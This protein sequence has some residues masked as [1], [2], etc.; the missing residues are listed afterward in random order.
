MVQMLPDAVSG[1]NLVVSE[2][3]GNST[4]LEFDPS[5]S[6]IDGRKGIRVATPDYGRVTLTADIPNHLFT[7]IGQWNTIE[8]RVIKNYPAYEVSNLAPFVIQFT[9]DGLPYPV[10]M[11]Y[12]QNA[13][14]IDTRAAIFH[15]HLKSDNSLGVVHPSSVLI[16][17]L[18]TWNG[19]NE[20][21]VHLSF[22]RETPSYISYRYFVN[23]VMYFNSVTSSLAF[24]TSAN[25]NK[26][27]VQ[28]HKGVS[29]SL[30]TSPSISD[31]NIYA[32]TEWTSAKAAQ[33]WNSI[34]APQ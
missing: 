26:L 21:L 8:F 5:V 7:T 15:Y 24:N 19:I 11:F 3:L 17:P 25:A 29:A 23:G 32:N 27:V 10:T 13:G 1:Y 6:Q 20:Q 18:P 31:L 14:Q 33:A 28:L 9:S 2:I 4:G 22:K 12:Y 30:Y 16:N 34:I